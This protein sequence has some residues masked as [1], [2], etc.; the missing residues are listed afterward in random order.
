MMA[1]FRW[2]RPKRLV[3]SHGEDMGPRL[4]VAQVEGLLKGRRSAETFRLIMQLLEFQRQLCQIAVQDKSNGAAG[5]TLF[6][7]GG[8]ASVQDVMVMVRAIE[9]G[10]RL[11]ADLEAWFGGRQRA[12]S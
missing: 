12:E 3:F 10:E 6:E 9:A 7:A 5:Q 2:F 8:A 4:T 1:L 11:P